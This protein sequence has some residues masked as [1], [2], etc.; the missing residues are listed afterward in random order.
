MVNKNTSIQESD[1]AELLPAAAKRPL[2]I[3]FSHQTAGGA[4]QVCRNAENLSMLQV[5]LKS[6]HESLHGFRSHKA[7]SR[8]TLSPHSNTP[9][10]QSVLSRS[11]WLLQVPRS[12]KRSS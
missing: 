9:S 12:L 6:T 5:R 8:R 11:R 4:R 10:V 7:L 3:V 1:F 2:H